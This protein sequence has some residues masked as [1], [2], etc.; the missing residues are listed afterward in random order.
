MKLSH[1]WLDAAIMLVAIAIC[2]AKDF[3]GVLPNGGP[4]PICAI[5]VE[6]TA[7]RPSL[8]QGQL[9]ALTSPDAVTYMAAKQY[10]FFVV[11][12]D[13]KTTEPAIVRAFADAKDTQKPCLV[14]YNKAGTLLHKATLTTEADMIAELKRRGGS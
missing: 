2:F 3:S 10:P 9:D 12:D 7:D 1:Q 11:D 8:T 6:E 14:I 5:V 13:D 4:E